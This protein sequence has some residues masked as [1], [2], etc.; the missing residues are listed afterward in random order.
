MTEGCLSIPGAYDEVL[1]PEKIKFKALD[2]H[3]KP[4]LDRDGNSKITAD[5]LFAR[6][7]QHEFDHLQGKL[8]IHYLS[9]LKRQRAIEQ[10][11]K[12]IRSRKK[13]S[14]HLR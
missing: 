5:G 8:F 4:L 9:E 1:R 7:I 2:R 12:T 14:N 13:T 6:C 3:G 10:Y 11:R